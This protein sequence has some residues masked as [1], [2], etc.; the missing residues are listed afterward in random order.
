M[1]V[2]QSHFGMCNN[3]CGNFRY[4]GVSACAY[5]HYSDRRRPLPCARDIILH[6]A[7]GACEYH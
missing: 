6:S 2:R 4:I 3:R 1:F 5:H 7:G